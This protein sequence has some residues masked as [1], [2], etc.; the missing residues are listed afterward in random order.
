MSRPAAQTAA[1]AA[2]APPAGAVRALLWAAAAYALCWSLVPPLLV[3]S[4][5]LDVIESL[6]W[7]HEWQWGYYKHP[8]LAPWVLELSLRAFGRF[9][10][11]LLSQLCVAAT[12]WLVWRT[13]LRLTTPA[14]A[15]TGAA[16][17]LGVAY[18]TWPALEFNH[19]IA[20]MPL[21]AALGWAMLAA[22]QQGRWR[23]W[24]WLGLLAG[25]GLLT[26]YSVGILLACLG[27]YV[28]LSP[29]R[30][31]LAGW[32]PWLALGTALLVLA[33]HLHWLWQSGGLPFAYAGGRAAQTGAAL[34]LRLGALR[35]ALTQLLAHLPL[36]LIVLAAAWPARRGMAPAEAPAR[37]CWHTRWP[38]YLLTLAL[39]PGTLTV[40]LGLLSGARVRDM[41]GS[42]MWA[43]SGLL[44]A[45]LL[46]TTV[47]RRAGPRLARGLGVWLLLASLLS[48]A[49]LAWGARWRQQPTRTD[50]PAAALAAQAQASWQAL[51]SCPL[52][53]VAGDYWLAGLVAA[54]PG[55]P[56]V[57]IDGD[58]R[59]SPWVT[60]QRLRAHGALWL[61]LA[62]ATPL[63]PPAPLDA[64]R[65]DADLVPRD[66]RWQLPWPRRTDGQPLSV[67]WRAYVPRACVRPQ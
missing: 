36:A 9:G 27:G 54:G 24:L 1:W 37:W 46:P 21:W 19:N 17:T 30:R 4:L 65:A 12:L 22:L 26:K 15:L 14:R 20:Q 29:A 62:D 34:E 51:S 49:Y 42:P 2:A 13:G 47:L 44:L 31:V 33:P 66:G 48:A 61:W 58:A 23:D 40:V 28:L 25:L 53:V 63:A 3:T 32:G 55:R 57:L 5:P 56:S 43:F 10:P 64:L 7:G 8:P 50:W 67:H 38:G 60:A 41:W 52:D 35:F 6:G 45:V 18:Y 39:A 16:L 59:F 11:F